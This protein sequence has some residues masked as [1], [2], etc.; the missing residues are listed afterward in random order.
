MQEQPDK[1]YMLIGTWKLVN[2]ENRD[3]LITYD[4]QEVITNDAGIPQT[5]MFSC[6]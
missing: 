1:S 5:R 6:E 2:I 4:K 3:A